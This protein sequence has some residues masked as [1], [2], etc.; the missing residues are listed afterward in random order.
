MV[1]R[2][3]QAAELLEAQGISTEVIDLRTLK[4]L[5]IQAVVNSV[6]K[7]HRLLVVHEAC[8]AGGLSGEIVAQVTE[9]AFDELDAPVGRVAALDS[10]IPYSE[11]LENAVIPTPERIVAAALATLGRS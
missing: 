2:C 5:D 10:P 7:T 8:L 3:I 4:P 1:H 6:Q 9:R 11:V